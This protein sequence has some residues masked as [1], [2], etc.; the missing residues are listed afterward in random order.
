VTTDSTE[1]NESVTTPVPI[2]APNVYFI[3][4]RIDRFEIGSGAGSL[5]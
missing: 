1:S 5:V 2:S 4:Q 3:R